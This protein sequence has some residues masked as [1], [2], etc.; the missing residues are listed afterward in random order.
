MLSELGERILFGSDFPN[1]PYDY[2]AAMTA[3]TTLDGID[4][5][6]LRGVFYNNAARLFGLDFQLA[7]S[8]RSGSSATL[9]R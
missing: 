7:A 2:A 8:V 6:W 5:D 9:G 1:I 3:I 4:D